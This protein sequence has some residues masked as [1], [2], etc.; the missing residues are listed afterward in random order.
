MVNTLFTWQF[1]AIFLPLMFAIR[2]LQYYTEIR[3]F[4]LGVQ[5]GF[6]M[7]VNTAVKVLLEEDMLKS[8]KETPR[9]VDKNNL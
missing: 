5:Q 7:G 4:K 3:Y 6:V 9:I 2:L 8:S 1:W